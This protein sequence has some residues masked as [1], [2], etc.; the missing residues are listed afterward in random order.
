MREAIQQALAERRPYR[1]DYRIVHADGTL[2]WVAE[3]GRGV[4]EP[5][6]DR[7]WLDGVL[8]D[9]T[10]Q[11][12][13]EQ[14]R[15]QA[16]QQLKD[17]VEASRHEALHDPVTGLPNR[18]LFR[19]QLDRVVVD[20]ANGGR[21]FAV[22][23]LDLDGFKEINDTLGHPVGDQLLL[24][25]ARRLEALVQAPDFVARLG[26]DEFAVILPGVSARTAPDMVD[27]IREA[28]DAAVELDGVAVRVE[29]SVGIAGYPRDGDSAD[30]ILRGAD[31]AMYVAKEARSG[32]AICS[33]DGRHEPSRLAL[34]NELRRAIDNR[35]LF[36]AY[37][38]KVSLVTDTIVGV[39]ALVRWRH[40]HRGLVMPDE[41]IMIAQQ[42]SLI[43]PL[44]LYVLG[45]ALDQLARWRDQG[46][47]LSMAVN[48]SVRNLVDAG[49][50]AEVRGLPSVA[51]VPASSLV[52]EITES[53][54]IS[55][56]FHVRVVLDELAA[57]GVQISIDDFGT[58]YSSLSHLKRLPI[59]EIKIDRSF[60]MNLAASD[61]DAIIVRVDG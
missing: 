10:Q 40:P 22:L 8:L 52:L 7:V 29:A 5:G 38:P 47:D 4:V 58:G 9:V 44:T 25:V 54:L 48:L 50:P 12:L 33:P 18:T 53:A 57:M 21:E 51:N 1:L 39:E 55:D 16:E 31:A 14:A 17:L 49:L 19:D 28:L 56:P 37:Q 23:M 61:E 46:L 20:A 42:T 36:L 60:V 30:V 3:H 13:A 34:A 59:H 11:K 45:E 43:R 41:F 35:E 15:D 6:G 26:G 27:R 2:R 24:E 32:Y